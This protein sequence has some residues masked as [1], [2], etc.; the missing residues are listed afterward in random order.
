M[1]NNHPTP[2]LSKMTRLERQMY[3]SSA[4]GELWMPETVKRV[5]PRRR[6][7]SVKHRAIR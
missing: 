4:K 2:D 6:R 1:T 7:N 5:P 3:F